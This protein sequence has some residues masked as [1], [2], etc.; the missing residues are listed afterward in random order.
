MLL[1]LNAF[2]FEARIN[3]TADDSGRQGYPAPSVRV[4]SF[5][6][7][8]CAFIP[9]LNHWVSAIGGAHTPPCDPVEIDPILLALTA[10]GRRPDPPL[11]TTG[12]D[13]TDPALER[14]ND[15]RFS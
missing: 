5:K 2:R 3:K 1:V 9:D 10:L 12:R 8:R 7:P 15:A 14:R 11:A 6:E 4:E 13:F